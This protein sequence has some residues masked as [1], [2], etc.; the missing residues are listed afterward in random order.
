M[1]KVGR[2]AGEVKTAKIE[3]KLEPKMKSEFQRLVKEKGSNS[4]VTICE[5]ISEYIKREGGDSFGK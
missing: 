1:A 2:P 3:V 4:S 5:L